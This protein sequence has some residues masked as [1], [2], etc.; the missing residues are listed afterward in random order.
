[1]W[2]EV[3]QDLDPSVTSLAKTS[4]NCT[5]KLQTRP[6]VREGTSNYKIHTREDNFFGEKEN[7]VAGPIW[8]PDDRQTG[9]LTVVTNTALILASSEWSS[10]EE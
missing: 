6:L 3:L 4:R 8:R 2:S 9:R 1:M 5:S 7:P 10:S